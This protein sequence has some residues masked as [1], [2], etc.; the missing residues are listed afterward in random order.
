MNSVVEAE[1]SE[2]D[3]RKGRKSLFQPVMVLAGKS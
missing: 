2:N 1:A 3:S